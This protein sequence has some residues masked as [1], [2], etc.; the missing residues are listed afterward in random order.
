MNTH[1]SSTPPMAGPDPA[2]LASVLITDKLRHRPY[3]GPNYEAENQALVAL[4]RGMAESPETVLTLLT[5]KAI[6]LCRAHTAGI[7]IEEGRAAD[8]VFRWR[9][10]AGEWKKFTGGTLPRWFSPCATVLD[11]SRPLLMSNLELAYAIPPELLP[12]VEEVLLVPFAGR[13]GEYVGTVWIISHERGRVFDREDLRM[14]E[15]LAAFAGAAYQA[16]SRPK[17]EER[18]RNSVQA[19]RGNTARAARMTMASCHCPGLAHAR[20]ACC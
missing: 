10:V 14:M 7:S 9:T 1:R 6:E 11:Q 4:M 18:R 20:A 2:A 16:L 13:G 3:R 17:P 8:S 19:A 15:S 5:E 12:R